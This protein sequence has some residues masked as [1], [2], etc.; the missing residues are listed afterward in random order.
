MVISARGA[1]S[2]QLSKFVRRTLSA[3]QMDKFCD[4]SFAKCDA[5]NFNGIRFNWSMLGHLVAAETGRHHWYT[6]ENVAHGF[7]L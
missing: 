7:G 3:H 6:I 2:T 1:S 4:M 5:R